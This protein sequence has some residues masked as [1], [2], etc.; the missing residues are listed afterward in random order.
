[1][2]Y[3]QNGTVLRVPRDKIA[4]AFAGAKAAKE[5]ISMDLNLLTRGDFT[6]Q[7]L[8]KESMPA[9]IVAANRVG[10]SATVETLDYCNP[11]AGINNFLRDQIAHKDNP[12][13]PF[14]EDE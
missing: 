14:F 7:Y 3:M 2:L 10:L 8:Y 12:Y 5:Q 9:C 11:S 6:F 1:M 4:A 13:Y